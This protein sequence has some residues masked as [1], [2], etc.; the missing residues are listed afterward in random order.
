MS[1]NARATPLTDLLRI[2]R[3]ARLCY[4]HNP[5]SHSLIPVGIYCNEAADEIERLRA[6]R[7]RD[8]ENIEAWNEQYK[9]MNAEV[10]M[11]RALLAEAL[12]YI[13]GPFDARE[14]IEAALAAGRE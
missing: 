10:N 13:A 9:E 11:L 7:R 3:D 6:E 4:E 12:S 1:D 8:A 14:R 5:T 2:P